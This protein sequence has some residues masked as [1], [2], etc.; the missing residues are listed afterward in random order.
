LLDHFFILDHW[1]GILVANVVRKKLVDH[2]D[3]EFHQRVPIE[4]TKRVTNI[5]KDVEL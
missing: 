2:L 3:D 5:M 4:V 1:K